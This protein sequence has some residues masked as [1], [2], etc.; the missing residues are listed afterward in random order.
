MFFFSLND[1]STLEELAE[2]R[3]HIIRVQQKSPAEIPFML[4]GTK[5]DAPDR[6][7]TI[8]EFR[9]LAFN[10]MCPF[11]EISAVK[12]ENIEEAFAEMVR[13]I[14]RKTSLVAIPPQ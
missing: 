13:A 9:A 10:Y 4:V 8:D 5:S 7:I 11:I 2:W 1:R 3:S 12:C 14:D 6:K